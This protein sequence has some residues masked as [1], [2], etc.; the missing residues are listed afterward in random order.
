M[1]LLYTASDGRLSWTKDYIG[2]EEI[3]PYAIL[4]H[5][6][7]EQEVIFDDLKSLTSVEDTDAKSKAGWDKMRFC[8]QQAKRDSLD[9]F[10][11]DTCC[12]DKSNSSELQEAINSMFCWYQ[13]AKKC[14]VYLSDVEYN[15]LDADSESSRR[16]KPAFRK[17]RWF[18]RGW[19]LQEL[20]APRSVEFFSKEG[21]LLGD[22]RSLRD[23][24]HE[25]TGIPIE[26]LLG[27]QLSQFSTAERFSWAANRQ[28]KREEDEA[29][30]L[31]GIFGIYLPLIYGEQ[32]LGAMKR[33]LNELESPAIKLSQA[34][35][36]DTKIVRG[37]VPAIMSGIDMV[38]QDQDSAKYRRLLDW[39]SAS[40]Y[41][42]Q[43][44]DIIKRRQEG[45]GQWFLDAPETARW[46]NTAMATLFCPGIPGAGKTMIAA[47]AID[48]LLDTVQSDSCGVVY[49]YCNYK[50][51][52]EQD[53]SSLLAAIL[54]QLV[55]GQLS[56]VNHIERLHQKH[57]S[58]GTKPSLDEIY[59]ALQNV[60]ACYASVHIV[61][62]ALDECQNATRRQLL[63]KLHDLQAG[64]DVR[65]MVTARFMPD[66]QDDFEGAL[67]LEVQA[68]REDVKRFVAGQI[69]RLPTC[70]QGSD[71]LQEM[72]QEKIA[73]AVDGMFLLA[74][75]HVDS[76][77]DKRTRKDVKTSLAKITKG[78]AALE[79][80]YREAL[81]RI[82]G[83]LEG[84]CG[85]AKKVLSWITFAK[86]PLTTAEICCALA[87]ETGEAEIDPDNVPNIKDLVSVCAGL[88]VVDRE[89]AI[90]RLVHYTTQ[91]YFERTVNVWYPGGQ[92]HIATTCLTYLS[93]SAF[94]GGSSSTDEEFEERLQQNKFLDY[95]AKHWGRHARTVE[96][97]VATFAC[98]LLQGKSFPSV[99]QVL[100]ATYFRYRGY[101]TKYPVITALHYT[102]RFGL[103]GITKK[104][105]D[106]TEDLIPKAVNVRDSYGST[107]LISAAENGQYEVV[108][109]LLDNNADVNVQGG[110]YGNAL[111][112]ASAG[113]HEQ[114]VKM[115]LDKGANMLLDNDADV[116]AQGGEYGNALQAASL[117]GHKEIVKVLLKKG[118]DNSVLKRFDEN[119]TASLKRH[120]I[121][122]LLD[123]DADVNAQ[124]RRYSNAL[125]AASAGGYKQLVNMLVA[126]GTNERQQKGLVI[127]P[128]YLCLWRL[129][130]W[131]HDA[132]GT[133]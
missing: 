119:T 23:T 32:R 13:N 74:R 27:S 100:G 117:E 107:P 11:V 25:I 85:L 40:D 67:R 7:G 127:W 80:A 37:H 125:Q 62:D 21:E 66:I 26:A 45:T 73:D 115:L 114:I 59:N 94:Q 38:R 72:V 110:R 99:I 31:L 12:I 128:G 129:G 69:Y 68:S 76:L 22:K 79:D 49:V 91:E 3:P 86:R 30:C 8:A 52:E 104:I 5:T 63:A 122:M 78:A 75:L 28:T 53:A 4:S 71:A 36:E 24:I 123:N 132:R 102:A 6:W 15:T 42:T 41:P 56:T 81:H 126:A 35:K 10:W 65:F 2:N 130:F 77:L 64:R 124:S 93:F 1:R 97:E 90:I 133:F 58:R 51:Q 46:L 39:I 54:K 57:A 16:W 103:P 111:Q 87:V 48:Y 120:E 82:E 61:I 88:V 29:Y 70:I 109:L 89:S 33:L 92:L 116:N 20:L 121:K 95:A 19:T 14:Y 98:K 105:L 50:A 113:G 83:Q 112:A 55:Q 47:I 131:N 101:S 84:D 44:S 96:A 17:S 108:Q 43:Q 60:F 106:A 18:T 118:A 34:I 9:Y